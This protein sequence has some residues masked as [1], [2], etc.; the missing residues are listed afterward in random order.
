M[1]TKTNGNGGAA[2]AVREERGA[3]ATG[4]ASSVQLR[5]IEDVIRLSR[6]LA[7]AHGFVPGHLAGKAPAIAAAILTGVELGLGAM[8]AMRSIH[9]VNGKPQLSADLMLARAIRAGIRVTWLR[10]DEKMAHAKL[11][12]V[13]FTPHEETFS[14]EDAKRAELLKNPTWSKYPK[15][16]LRAR[17]I[18]AAMRA[19]APDVL[20]SGVYVEGE[21]DEPDG[22]PRPVVAE[23]VENSRRRETRTEQQIADAQGVVPPEKLTDCTSELEVLAWC[24]VQSKHL[25]KAGTKGQQYAKREIAKACERTGTNLAIALHRA[26]LVESKAAEAPPETPA[27]DFKPEEGEVPAGEEPPPVIG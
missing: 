18:S 1:E 16:M 7:E 12:R 17:C 24:D 25:A 22:G 5:G 26:G 9:I 8:E 6:M 4:F 3:L 19:F 13:G 21:I 23:V 14:I 15:A 11:E 20:G 2:L 10:S 27:D